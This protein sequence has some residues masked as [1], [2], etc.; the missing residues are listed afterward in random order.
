M[1]ESIK[2]ISDSFCYE[3]FLKMKCLLILILALKGIRYKQVSEVFAIVFVV[4]LFF[5]N[6]RESSDL[7]VDDMRGIYKGLI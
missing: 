1:F 6:L 7:N 3:A 2:L 5:K 4:V